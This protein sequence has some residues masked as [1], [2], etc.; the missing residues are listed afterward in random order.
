M[1]TDSLGLRAL[2]ALL[3]AGVALG[4]MHIACVVGLHVPFDPNEGWNAYFAQAA[5]TTGSPYPAAGSLLIDNYPPLSFYLVGAVGKLSGDAVVAGRIVALAALFA[6]AL[7]IEA[8]ARR[9]GCSRIEAAFAALFFTAGVMLTS[10]YAGMDDPQMLG[11]A[12]AIGG[13]VAVLREPRTPRAMVAAALLF[14]LAFFV[15]HNLVVLP[16]AVA[17]WLALLDRRAAATFAGSGIVFALI[18]LGLFKQAYGFSLFSVIDSARTFSFA[19]IETAGA[20]WLR[21][22]A[23]PLLGAAAMYALGRRDRHVVLC[24][25]Y[26]VLA[27]VTGLYFSGG[28]G[29]DAN[30]LF[31]ADIAVALSAGVLMNR[32]PAGQS[33]AA[34]LYAVPLALGVAN[35][36]ADWRGSDYWLHPMAEDRA[37][38]RAQIALLRGAKGPVLCEMLS[39]CYWAGKPAE[40]DVFNIEQAYL[41]SARSDADLVHAIEARHYA[42]VQLEEL[43]PFPLTPNVHRALDQNYRIVLQDD[44]RVIFAPR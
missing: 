19:N 8:A 43:S 21:W 20:L 23:I 36:Q 11:H 10:D 9:M 13:L 30:A 5:M 4:L 33:I 22:S 44:D 3:A 31:D 17:A 12:V 28:A 40:V 2:T 41:T 1:T 15:K 38:A 32:L 16:L 24:A 37:A 27:T 42:L 39:L 26:V 25:I 34:A 35:L 7:G 6:A 18:G 14:T 29:V